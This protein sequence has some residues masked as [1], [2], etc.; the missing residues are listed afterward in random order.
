MIQYHGL[1]NPFVVC[2]IVK[3]NTEYVEVPELGFRGATT[4]CGIHKP[5]FESNE[6]LST[7]ISNK[8]T[9]DIFKVK[10]GEIKESVLLDKSYID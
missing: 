10:N 5:E 8:E 3:K 9:V 6:E 7:K 1:I 2:Q 4:Y